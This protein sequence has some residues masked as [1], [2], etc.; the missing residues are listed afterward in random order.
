MYNL[1]RV[2]AVFT[3][4]HARQRISLAVINDRQDATV[5]FLARIQNAKS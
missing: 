1:W 5:I 2:A 4:R 3:V